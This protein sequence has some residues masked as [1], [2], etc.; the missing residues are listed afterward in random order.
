MVGFQ[1]LRL[2]SCEINEIVYAVIFMYVKGIFCT[3]MYVHVFGTR[4]LDIVVGRHVHVHV[5]GYIE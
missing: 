2:G 3:Y 4:A 5:S 1:P